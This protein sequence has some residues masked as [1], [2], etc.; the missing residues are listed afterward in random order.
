MLLAAR[1]AL[2]FAQGIDEAAF[3]NRRLRQNPVIRALE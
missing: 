1:D 2:S 3:R